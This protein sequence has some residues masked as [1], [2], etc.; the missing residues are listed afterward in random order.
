M[1]SP[2][3]E[4]PT[5]IAGYMDSTSVCFLDVDNQTAALSQ[6]V[7]A[8]DKAD[9]LIDR[10]VF[11]Q[12]IVEREKIGSTG[13]GIGVAIP[14]AKLKGY[15]NFFIAIGIQKGRGIEWNALDGAPVRIIFM[16]GGPENRQTEYLKILSQLT[17]AIKD[18]ERR[19]ALL[20]ATNSRD[21]LGVFQG[22]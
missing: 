22:L 17:S 20:K 13:I 3:K 15:E 10:E 11:Y 8:L 21:I 9:K 1:R 18:E 4:S 14:H 5:G 6:L 2:K 7:D 12:A 19:K 16:I